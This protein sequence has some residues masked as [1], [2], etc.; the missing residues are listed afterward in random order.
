MTVERRLLTIGVYGY[1][2]AEFF[3]RLVEAGVDLFV[4]IRARRGV[5]GAEY[6]FA[7]SA[8][9]Q[10]RLHELD[11]PY[12][13][14]PELAPTLAIIKA[15]GEEDRKEHVARRKRDHL[16]DVF[17]RRYKAEVLDH[18]DPQAFVALVPTD[19]RAICLFCVERDPD[20]CHR[21]LSAPVLAA[22]LHARVEHLT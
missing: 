8:R 11:I 20:A 7:N 10:K 19:A 2:E 21:S 4:D 16:S 9:L 5:R 13:H 15:Q 17:I 14:V 18:Y 6:A 3:K 12:L 22:A 1:S